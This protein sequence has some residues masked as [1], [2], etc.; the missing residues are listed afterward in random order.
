MNPVEQAFPPP[1][2]MS[3]HVD[4]P[5]PEREQ[6]RELIREN[7]RLRADLILANARIVA[8]EKRLATPCCGVSYKDDPCQE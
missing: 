5:P 8:L 1:P 2:E 6:L 4:S 3:G 7:G